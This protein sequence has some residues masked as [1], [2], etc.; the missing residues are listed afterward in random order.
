MTLA[1]KRL[2]QSGDTH[3]VNVECP[4]QLNVHLEKALVVVRLRQSIR[5][6]LGELVGNDCQSRVRRTKRIN[7]NVGRTTDHER[8]TLILLLCCSP[9]EHDVEDAP[10]VPA[11]RPRASDDRLATQTQSRG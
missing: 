9:C 11:Q 4:H 1:A 3:L 5:L 6:T 7:V 2:D 10:N 8:K